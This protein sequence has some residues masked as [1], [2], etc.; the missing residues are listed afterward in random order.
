MFT[1]RLAL[2]AYA[3]VLFFF[4]TGAVQAGLVTI[5]PAAS[6]VAV[7]EVFSLMTLMDFEDTTVGGGM[8][9]TREFERILV[10]VLGREISVSSNPEVS[11]AG[12][13]L[14]ARVA[15]NEFTSLEEAALWTRPSLKRLEPDPLESAEYEDHYQRWLQVAEKLE[16]VGL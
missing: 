6:E 8:T 11:A 4:T 14:S 16:E 5:E 10:N 9:R 2:L 3:Y 15:L 13:Y 12:A 7:G 1:N